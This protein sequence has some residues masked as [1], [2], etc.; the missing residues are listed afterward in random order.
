[1]G[2]A[3]IRA[4]VQDEACREGAAFPSAL[5]HQSSR[6]RAMSGNANP[7][8]ASICSNVRTTVFAKRLFKYLC[9]DR[10]SDDTGEDTDER[11]TVIDP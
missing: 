11:G 10:Y 3:V 7:I 9:K 6:A 4:Q 2:V 5:A 1:M 8:S